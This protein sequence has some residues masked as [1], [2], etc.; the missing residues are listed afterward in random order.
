M[1]PSTGWSQTIG[2]G[3]VGLGVVV[4]IAAAAMHRRFL[5]RHDRNLPYQPPAFSLEIAAAIVLAVLGAA[6]A[7]HLATI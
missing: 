5:Q 1:P 2:L 7:Y 4:N 6:T 3:L